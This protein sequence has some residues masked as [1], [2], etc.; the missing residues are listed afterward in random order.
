MNFYESNFRSRPLSSEA[1]EAALLEVGA[2]SITSSTAA[3][4]SRAQAREVEI[5][6]RHTGARLFSRIER[7]RR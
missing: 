7:R 6:E 4:A 5:V 3:T 2:S 1:V